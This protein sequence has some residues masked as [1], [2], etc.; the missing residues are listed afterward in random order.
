LGTIDAWRLTEGCE[1]NMDALWRHRPA[2]RWLALACLLACHAGVRAVGAN[3]PEIVSPGVLSGPAHDSAPAFSPDGREVVFTRSSS[4]LSTILVSHRLGRDWSEPAIAAFSGEWLEME[5]AFS[6]DGRFLVYA[7]NRPDEDG[8]API[9]GFFNGVARPGKGARLWRVDRL[10][11]GWSRPR[12]LPPEINDGHAVYAPSVAR[13]GS[14]YF[15]KPGADGRFQ[16][17]RAQAE[18]AGFRPA[19]RMS[20]N[21]AGAASVDPAVAPDESFIVF[22]SNRRPARG[23]DLFIAYR[24]GDGWGCAIHLGEAVNSA[25]SDAE[26]R[27]SP[28]ARTLYFASDRTG[29]VAFPST[30]RRTEAALKRMH[31]WDNGNY[32][33]WR[34]DLGPW[35]AREE[36][37]CAS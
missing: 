16:V 35:L 20:F 27:L 3:A 17:F 7:S 37:A 28:D 29:E 14:L 5:P 25:G 32:N 11:H 21:E 30:R 22:S 31:D 6:P 18:G 33:I 9:D 10:P 26:A 13:D 19:E 8:G 24:Q 36:G 2:L 4:S 12:L 34:V 1:V 15:M 23:M